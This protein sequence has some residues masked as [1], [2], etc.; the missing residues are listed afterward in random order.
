MTCDAGP[1]DAALARRAANGDERAFAELVRRHGESLYKML[2]RY[3]G[4][5]DDA[6]EAAHEAF[7]AAWSAL[8]R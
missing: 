8:S 6:Y 2:R 3:T 1:P 5:P 7:I 4:D